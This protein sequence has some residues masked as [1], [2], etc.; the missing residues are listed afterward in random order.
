M[1]LSHISCPFAIKSGIVSLFHTNGMCHTRPRTSR[2]LREAFYLI[3][4]RDRLF[5]F[6]LGYA[7]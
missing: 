5:D 2:S 4:G 6:F 7:F 1:K 3:G